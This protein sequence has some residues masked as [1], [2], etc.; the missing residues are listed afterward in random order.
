MNNLRL[1]QMKNLG[2][3]LICEVLDQMDSWDIF[4]LAKVTRKF[5]KLLVTNPAIVFGKH[6]HRYTM[7]TLCAGN[8]LTPKWGN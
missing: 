2:F 4:E 7:N 3:D 1:F 6:V 5:Q 8:F